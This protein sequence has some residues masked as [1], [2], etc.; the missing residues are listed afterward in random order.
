MS[1]A[2]VLWISISIHALREE[3]DHGPVSFSPMNRLF[4]STPSARRATLALPDLRRQGNNF[5][6]RPPRG[7]RPKFGE[8]TGEFIE[9]LSTPSAR[10]ATLADYLGLPTKVISIH[11]L[12]EEGD[13]TTRQKKT[14][15]PISIHALR[16]EGDVR[17][18]AATSE[19]TD[20][21]P[22]PPRGGRPIE[23]KNKWDN[24]VISIHALRE[25]GDVDNVKRLYLSKAF[26]STPSARRATAKT[27]SGL[28]EQQFLSTP[29]ARRAT[30]DKK[31]ES[32]QPK[33]SIH[34]L[35]EEGDLRRPC[36][37][38]G[39][40]HF[41]PR[42]PRGGRHQP[43]LTIYT[44]RYFYPRPP[45]GGR[46]S[47][48][49][50]AR[51]VTKY[52]YP[53]PP[54]GGRRLEWHPAYYSS[55]I[56]IHALREEGDHS[57]HSKTSSTSY[58]YPRPPRGGRR[59][60]ETNGSKTIK[61]LSTPSARRATY[62]QKYQHQ[63]NPISIHA[64]REEGDHSRHS[65][66]SSTSYF[67]PR[68]PRG[69]RRDSETNGSKTIKFLS[70][71]SARRATYPQKYQHQNNPISIHALREEGDLMM[72]CS[73]VSAILFLSTPSARRATHFE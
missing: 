70:T 63:N 31:Y 18:S 37:H 27:F 23:V 55:L 20:F 29:S 33:I 34:A 1:T 60:S 15:Q 62:P 56:S 46:R 4:L 7:G 48:G 39:K 41:Y 61:F 66:T 67:Y 36:S 19:A 44:G 58:F 22:R 2:K 16:E 8:K 12:R 49:Q 5:Y 59:D 42:P 3:G 10:R 69:G 54:R 65:K 64:L 24:D 57:R 40:A 38:A 53:R 30:F 32:E 51:G 72:L 71:P 17:T 26:L 47:R 11:A 13:A 6:P 9:F 25:E 43:K 28:F 73:S 21:Y 50:Q 52:F 14:Q 45:R 68:P 35:R